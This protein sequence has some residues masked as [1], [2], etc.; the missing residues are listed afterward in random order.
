MTGCVLQYHLY[1]RDFIEG[2]DGFP[3][4]VRENRDAKMFDA[5]GSNI[6]GTF[7]RIRFVDKSAVS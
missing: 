7:Q 6:M 2:V 4:L 3:V 5:V 1:L